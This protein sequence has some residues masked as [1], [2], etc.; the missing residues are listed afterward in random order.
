MALFRFFISLF[1]LLPSAA[2]AQYTYGLKTVNEKCNKG[3]AA[4]SISGTV[5]GDTVEIRWSTGAKNR[6]SL[7]QL[8]PGSYSVKINI[9]HTR[10]SLRT[11]KDTTL[12][13]VIEKELCPVSI[14]K[15]FSPNS[16]G[17]ADE[18]H[19]GFIEK[20]PGFELYIYNKW[21]QTV[22]IQKK[23]YIPW[24]GTW[25]GMQLP[26]GAYYYVFFFDGNDKNNII[27]GDITILR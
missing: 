12:L 9:V 11:E 25:N 17:Y 1:L 10:D 7:Q 18:L 23:T 21:G 14:P 27:K 4:L 16:D 8:E 20:H 15:Y 22:H 3:S 13:F 2:L 5:E 19:I 6:N 24:N 26:D